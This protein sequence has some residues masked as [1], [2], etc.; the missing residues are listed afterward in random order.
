M[1]FFLKIR[2][3][4]QRARGEWGE[5]KFGRTKKVGIKIHVLRRLMKCQQLSYLDRE[6]NP[7]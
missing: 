4:K 5:K 2:L 3:K 6:K 1:L 7:R